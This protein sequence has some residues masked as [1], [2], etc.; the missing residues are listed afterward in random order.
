MT[1]SDQNYPTYRSP[2]LVLPSTTS[3][4]QRSKLMSLPCIS[5]FELITIGL[6]FVESDYGSWHKSS[7]HSHTGTD[8]AVFNF[9]SIHCQ[10]PPL[11]VKNLT[12]DTQALNRAH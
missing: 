3:F 1:Y 11:L 10:Q 9:Y 4:V 2:S 6:L 7:V 5:A 12:I 8:V